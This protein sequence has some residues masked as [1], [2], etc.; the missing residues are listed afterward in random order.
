MK[1]PGM[2]ERP[3]RTAAEGPYRGHWMVTGSRCEAKPARSQG[4]E[5]ER[6]I[7]AP[8]SRAQVASIKGAR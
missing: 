5:G 1:P 8:V 3:A 6:A 2:G 7:G 4:A